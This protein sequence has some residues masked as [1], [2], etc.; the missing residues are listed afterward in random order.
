MLD[1]RRYGEVLDA[2]LERFA[3]T[4]A[5][6]VAAGHTGLQEYCKMKSPQCRIMARK[7]LMAQNWP[8]KERT[9]SDEKAFWLDLS[10]SGISHTE[11]GTIG[12]VVLAGAVLSREEAP[13]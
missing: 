5:L 13:Q 3:D 7:A 10:I 11:S 6:S 1:D 8:F 12:G 9:P 4:E 2:L